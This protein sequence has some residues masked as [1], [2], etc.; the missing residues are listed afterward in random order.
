MKKYFAPGLIL[1]VAGLYFLIDA[2]P[3]VALPGSAFLIAVGL[4]LLIARLATRRCGFSIA[5]FVVLCLGLGWTAMELLALPGAYGIVITLLALALAFL[6]IHICEFR[7]IGNWPLLPALILLFFG[8]LF[9]LVLTPEISAVLRPYYGLIFPVVLIGLG[10]WLLMRG[11][12]RDRRKKQAARAQAAAQA[13]PE[14]PVPPEDP[15]QPSEPAQP[16]EPVQPSEPVQPEAP[17]EDTASKDA[18]TERKDVP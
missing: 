17:T 14:V 4:A 16:E 2:L 9:F 15:A 8:A 6:L 7:R 1:I 11:L 10:V 13:Q 5:G 12:L 18:P 3:G